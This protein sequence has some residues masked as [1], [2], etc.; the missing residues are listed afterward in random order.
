MQL[1]LEVSLP[2]PWANVLTDVHKITW[3]LIKYEDS[4]LKMNNAINEI[5]ITLEGTMSSFNIS[6]ILFAIFGLQRWHL[7]K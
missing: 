3:M 2:S 7:F 1:S 4:Q 5:K 6:G